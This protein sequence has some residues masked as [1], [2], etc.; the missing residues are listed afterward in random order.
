MQGMLGA[1]GTETSVVLGWCS[2]SIFCIPCRDSPSHERTCPSLERQETGWG[3]LL[4]WRW[5]QLLKRSQTSV[6]KQPGLPQI[7]LLL[8]AGIHKLSSR[9]EQS[10]RANSR[11]LTPWGRHKCL[12]AFTGRELQLPYAKQ[13]RLACYGNGDKSQCLLWGLPQLPTPQRFIFIGLEPC[14]SE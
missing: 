1:L 11:Q 14:Y 2:L 7:T 10:C 6:G 13:E 3:L 5:T 8:E 4:F 9:F 12:V